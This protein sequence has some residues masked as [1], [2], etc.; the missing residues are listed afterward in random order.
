MV[1]VT[2]S[3]KRFRVW[4]YEVDE[5]WGEDGNRQPP[6]CIGTVLVDRWKSNRCW[7]ILNL[8]TGKETFGWH[9]KLLGEV[10]GEELERFWERYD[11]TRREAIK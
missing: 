7:Q 5:I 6:V 1:L 9:A 11:S 4:R 3:T 2:A 8:N 10:T